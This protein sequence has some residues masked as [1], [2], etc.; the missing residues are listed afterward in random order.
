MASS[1]NF[2]PGIAMMVEIAPSTCPNSSSG[3]KVKVA[4]VGLTKASSAEEAV[5]DSGQQ[6]E[7]ILERTQGSQATERSSSLSN[8]LVRTQFQSNSKTF[9]TLKSKIR[10]SLFPMRNMRVQVKSGSCGKI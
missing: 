8:L 7:A 9:M 5:V 2:L 10:S 1:V 6:S 4:V 3:V